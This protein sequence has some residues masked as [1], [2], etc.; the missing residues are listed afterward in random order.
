MS[1]KNEKHYQ[2]QQEYVNDSITLE[3]SSDSDEKESDQGRSQDECAVED[4]IFLLTPQY[5]K[6]ENIITPALAAALDKTRL[7]D[8]KAMFVVAATACSLGHVID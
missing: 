3:S 2:E 1:L 7:S 5:I 6:R 4:Q 8:R